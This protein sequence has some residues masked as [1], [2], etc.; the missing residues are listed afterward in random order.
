MSD[1]NA[2]ALL[3]KQSAGRSSDE[4]VFGVNLQ[5]LGQDSDDLAKKLGWRG[6]PIT[7]DGLRKGG[8]RW[9]SSMDATT[10][11]GR[12]VLSRT[13]SNVSQALVDSERPNLASE[14]NVK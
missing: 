3:D 11:M 4:R 5:N 10:Y 9:Q 1:P 14:A 7:T 13:A 8:P 12:W 6:K 2:V